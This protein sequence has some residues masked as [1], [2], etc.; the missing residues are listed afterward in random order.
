[1]KTIHIVYSSK[2]GASITRHIPQDQAWAF[3]NR[4]FKRKVE[5][6]AYES[7]PYIPEEAI[8]GVDYIGGQERGRNW[9]VWRVLGSMPVN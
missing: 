9:Q 6:R 5:A 2:R 8:G 7:Q 1:M 3:L 4:L